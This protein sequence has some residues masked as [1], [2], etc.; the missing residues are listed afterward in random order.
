MKRS[1]EM[2]QGG[3]DCLGRRRSDWEEEEEGG[4]QPRKH[5]SGGRKV[6]NK[7]VWGL[8]WEFMGMVEWNLLL[9]EGGG[10]LG[11]GKLSDFS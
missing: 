11:G 1:W 10:P 4:V 2:S 6:R 7:S 5:L 3:E 9:C 8:I